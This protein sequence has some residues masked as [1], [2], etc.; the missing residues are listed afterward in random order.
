[1]IIYRARGLGL[2][3]QE[4]PDRNPS[5]EIA[6]G[7]G[8]A[9]VLQLLTTP[10]NTGEI[11]RKLHITAGAASQHLSRLNDAGLVEPYRSGRRVYYHLTDRGAQ[12]LLL[13]DRAG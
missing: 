5:L 6:L 10:A 2:W 8:R 3:Q 11:A 4:E 9:R 1:M 13:F 12:L 7:A